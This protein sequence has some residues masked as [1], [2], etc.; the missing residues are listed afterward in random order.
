MSILI[1][2]VVG[3]IA[4][5]ILATPPGVI[6]L[7]IFHFLTQE[8]PR[9][10]LWVGAGSATLD[11][12]YAAL[13]LYSTSAVY[14]ALQ[15]FIHRNP[16][17]VAIL[18]FIF[19]LA[20]LIFGV[21]KLVHRGD[22]SFFSK[23]KYTSTRQNKLHPYFLGCIL[24]LTHILVPTF[25]PGYAYMAAMLIDAKLVALN[26]FHFVIFS[27]CFALG[28]FLWVIG[29]VALFTKLGKEIG[30]MHLKRIDKIIG[31]LFTLVG[32][33]MIMRMILSTNW[34]RIF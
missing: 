3:L 7:T 4:G 20:L 19:A 14:Q 23:L 5:I 27:L 15:G 9:H 22:G 12:F 31:I 11:I 2:I 10:S 24:A 26:N 34:Q 16:E 29:I 28:N 8:K 1:T 25:L 17:V 21:S 18:E 33:G 32:F 13:A 30:E 6:N